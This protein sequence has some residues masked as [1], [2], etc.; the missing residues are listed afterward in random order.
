MSN[1]KIEVSV[2]VLTYFHEDYIQDALNSVLAQKTRFNYEIVV[3]DDGSTD[4]TMEILEDY[5]KKYPKLIRVYHNNKNIGIPKNIY[6]ARCL[7]KGK[8][9]VVLAGDDYWINE[10]KIESQASFLEKHDNFVAVCNAME[11]RY[12]SDTNPFRTLPS[13]KKRNR[14]FNLKNYEN[15]ETLYTHGFMMRNFF[16]TEDGRAHFYKA[17]MISDKVDDAVDNVLLLQKGDV[18]ILDLITDVYRVPRVRSLAKNYN[19]KFS[20]IERIKNTI[21]LYNNMFD[22][23]EV[24]L[25]NKYSTTISIA[26]IGAL[27]SGNF[28][29]LL[30]V[31]RTIPEV[32]RKPFYSS[33]AMKSLPKAIIFS[34]KKLRFTLKNNLKFLG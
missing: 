12:D 23:L 10:N 3:C 9:I 27:L 25:K 15:G 18:F 22:L 13:K 4:R 6:K 11:L 16:L 7:C 24:N 8:Y 14:A 17:Q 20:R 5:S 29:D 31:Y 19:S 33:V 28:K 1:K 21:N 2:Y 30:K 26:L 32:Y 34:M